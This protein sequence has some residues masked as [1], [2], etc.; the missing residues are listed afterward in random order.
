MSSKVHIHVHGKAKDRGYSDVSS[1]GQKAMEQ[2]RRI[3]NLANGDGDAEDVKD[4]K[5]AISDLMET[6]SRLD[7]AGQRIKPLIQER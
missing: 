1:L 7:A 4:I 5:R 2:G 6:A 3:A